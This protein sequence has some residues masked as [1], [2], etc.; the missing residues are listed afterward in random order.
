MSV[1]ENI[2]LMTHYFKEYNAAKGDAAKLDA[3]LDK[4]FDPK[5]VWHLPTG[6]LK[7]EQAKQVGISIGK[8]FS[9]INMTVDDIIAAGDKV[10]T[11][12]TMRATHHGEYLGVAPTGKKI[13]QT[14]MNINRIARGKIAE[15]WMVNDTFGL[16]IQLGAVPNPFVQ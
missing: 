6:D 7:L 1:K 4:Y 15:T 9:D 14:G 2:E 16:M 11:R 5:F 12:Q 13:S 8:S 3:L 10:M